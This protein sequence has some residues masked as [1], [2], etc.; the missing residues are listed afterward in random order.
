MSVAPQ[1]NEKG[2]EKISGQYDFIS[3]ML[4]IRNDYLAWSCWGNFIAAMLNAQRCHNRLTQPVTDRVYTITGEYGKEFAGH[5]LSLKIFA[6]T[7]SIQFL[8]LP[9]KAVPMKT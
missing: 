9:N 8:M 3:L 2:G 7:T 5:D 6:S 1:T 4:L